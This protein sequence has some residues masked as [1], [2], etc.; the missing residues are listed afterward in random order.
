MYL[1][2]EFSPQQF[3]ESEVFGMDFANDVDDQ[4]QLI[5]SVW[6]IV[7]AQ[8]EDPNPTVHLEGLPIVVIPLG[9]NL[10]T[11]SIQRIGGL[12]PDVTYKV[13]ATVIT[14]RGNTRS[15]WTNIRGVNS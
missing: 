1:G 8:G 5:S 14:D 13:E 11:A 2:R 15:L 6:T 7:V 9:S 12:W 4:E 10:K 3:I